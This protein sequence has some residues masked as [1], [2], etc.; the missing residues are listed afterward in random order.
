[1]LPLLAHDS[2]PQAF[3]VLPLLTP[4][5]WACW[6]PLCH[7]GMLGLQAAPQEWGLYP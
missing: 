4:S 7:L 6:Y 1:M 3:S 2:Q 5:M